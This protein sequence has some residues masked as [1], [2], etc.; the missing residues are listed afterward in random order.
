MLWDEKALRWKN[1]EV[2]KVLQKNIEDAVQD[3]SYKLVYTEDDRQVAVTQGMVRAY[4][5]MLN[6]IADIEHE[7]EGE[8]DESG[9]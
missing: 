4:M 2:T 5:D 3:L 6:V 9:S 7:R 1:D 8:Q